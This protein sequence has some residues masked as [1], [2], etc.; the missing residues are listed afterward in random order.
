[1]RTCVHGE[2]TKNTGPSVQR[3]LPPRRWEEP[4]GSRMN[5]TGRSNGKPGITDG[6]PG[7]QVCS[8]HSYHLRNLCN[9]DL[10]S[11]SDGMLQQLRLKLAHLRTHS[12]RLL[13]HAPEQQSLYDVQN[14]LW[15]G[16]QHVFVSRPQ[17]LLQHCLEE[18]Q[19]LPRLRQVWGPAPAELKSICDCSC[20]KSTLSVWLSY[21]PMGPCRRC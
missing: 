18:V 4:A 6:I 13:M 15:K 21:A 10:R 7:P 12:Q 11:I 14:W 9:H 2:S 3:A 5:A 19:E 20:K 1:V 16:L 17:T 8:G